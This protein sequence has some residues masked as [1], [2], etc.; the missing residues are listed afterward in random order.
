LCP[1]GKPRHVKL[2]RKAANDWQR[3]RDRFIPPVR[4]SIGWRGDPAAFPTSF[5]RAVVWEASAAL[6]K[7]AA[8]RSLRIIEFPQVPGREESKTPQGRQIVHKWSARRWPRSGFLVEVIHPTPGVPSLE[9][10]ARPRFALPLWGSLLSAA[11]FQAALWPPSD[12]ASRLVAWS[13]WVYLLAA[14]A[15]AIYLL[16]MLPFLGILNALWGGAL[17]L[18]VGLTFWPSLVGIAIGAAAAIALSERAW[19][20]S[21]RSAL[22]TAIARAATA[23]AGS[24]QG[25]DGY[26]DVAL[27]P[28][29]D[30]DARP[31]ASCGASVPLWSLRCPAC[32]AGA[33]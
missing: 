10:I 9:F 16:R 18:I 15:V 7:L 12:L 29:R 23:A 13:I 27:L 24:S 21:L 31:C 2:R 26:T 3:I 22:D 1:S 17:L 32:G 33:A 30:G 20:S 14:G 11:A 25:P 4:R 6:A 28:D 5:T 19:G 8:D